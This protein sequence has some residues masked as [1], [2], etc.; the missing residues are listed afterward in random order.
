MGLTT[1]VRVLAV[2]DGEREWGENSDLPTVWGQAEVF[3]VG[4]TTWIAVGPFWN[5]IFFCH[6]SFDGGVVS[7]VEPVLGDNMA[8]EDV[9]FSGGFGDHYVRAVN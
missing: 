1:Y 8:G 6:A 5:S 3:R 9:A 4:F 7:V 2:V